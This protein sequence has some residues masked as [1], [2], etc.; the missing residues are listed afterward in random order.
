MSGTTAAAAEVEA[1]EG[2]AA[3]AAERTRPDL[4]NAEKVKASAFKYLLVFFSFSIVWNGI[5]F[6]KFDSFDKQS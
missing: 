4:G 5:L 3:E 6:N 2:V 1:R